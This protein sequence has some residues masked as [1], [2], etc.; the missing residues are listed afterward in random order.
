MAAS[1]MAR[2]A[3]S[4]VAAGG[5]ASPPPPLVELPVLPESEPFD[6]DPG[7]SETKFGPFPPLPLGVSVQEL[8]ARVVAPSAPSTT[9]FSSARRCEF[10]QGQQSSSAPLE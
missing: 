4:S 6:W 1:S 7:R 9:A 10:M 3:S 8:N 5:S 2:A